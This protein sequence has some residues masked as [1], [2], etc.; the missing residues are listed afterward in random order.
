M[1]FRLRLARAGGRPR[2]AILREL[3]KVIIIS[4]LRELSGDAWL[5]AGDHR[6]G[7]GEDDVRLHALDILGL[8]ILL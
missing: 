4:Y 1:A 5:N 2:Q 8:H 7:R 6:R 3:V